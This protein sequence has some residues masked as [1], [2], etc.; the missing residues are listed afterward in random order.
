MTGVYVQVGLKGMN[1]ASFSQDTWGRDISH[2]CVVLSEST[3]R[4]LQDSSG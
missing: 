3:E 2:S 1:K 4:E